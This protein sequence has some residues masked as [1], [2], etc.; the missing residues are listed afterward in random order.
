MSKWLLSVLDKMGGGKTKAKVRSE[1]SKTACGILQG[2]KADFSL[3]KELTL[4]LLS[5]QITLLPSAASL[6]A[7]NL[8]CFSLLFPPSR[9]VSTVQN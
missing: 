2:E 7:A 3:L 1:E 9:N 8:T 5:F 4:P 6:R